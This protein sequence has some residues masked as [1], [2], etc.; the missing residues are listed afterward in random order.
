MATEKEMIKTKTKNHIDDL[1]RATDLYIH[2]VK[3]DKNL[4]DKQ[5]AQAI[6]VAES[7]FTNAKAQATGEEVEAFEELKEK[8]QPLFKLFEELGYS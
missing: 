3:L 4:T 6:R 2:K 1:R 5:K 8:Y 7:Q